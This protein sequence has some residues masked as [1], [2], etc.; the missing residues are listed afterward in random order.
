MR[1]IVNIMADSVT[2][3][4]KPKLLSRKYC[5]ICK[6]VFRGKIIDGRIISLHR[7]PL[8]K[9]LKRV[10]IQRC[11]TVMRTF[12]WTEHKRLCSEHFVDLGGPTLKYTIPSLFPTEGGII[13]DFPTWVNTILS[14]Y[15]TSLGLEE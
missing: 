8:N 12:K 6:S 14:L 1:N 11:K 15:Y 4:Q 5:C 2:F 7:F 9:R 10:W 13:K 3:I